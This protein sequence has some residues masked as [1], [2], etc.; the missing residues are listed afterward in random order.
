MNILVSGAT[1]M[2]GRVIV[3]DCLSNSFN[4]STVGRSNPEI[5]EVDPINYDF[6][7]SSFNQIKSKR[8]LISQS[9]CCQY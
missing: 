7:N 8:P 9:L 4:V 1:G 6:S 5:P 2:L 3:K